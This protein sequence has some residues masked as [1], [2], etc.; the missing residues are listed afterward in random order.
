[1]GRRGKILLACGYRGGR[2]DRYESFPGLVLFGLVVPPLPPRVVGPCPVQSA[3][4]PS[5]LPLEGTSI[6]IFV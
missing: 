2:E 5:C 4:L 3:W 1:M 6:Q